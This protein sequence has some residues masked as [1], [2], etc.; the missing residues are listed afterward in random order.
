M[1]F[2]YQKTANGIPAG[3]PNTSGWGIL[4]P[5][6]LA[7]PACPDPAYCGVCPQ[8]PLAPGQGPYPHQETVYGGVTSGEVPLA[9]GWGVQQRPALP[10]SAMGTDP[11][12]ATITR[13]R[14]TLAISSPALAR[15]LSFLLFF[16]LCLF[17]FRL[18]C[19]HA[20]HAFLILPW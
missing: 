6:Q 1:A 2:T 10:A 3:F 8:P 15:V 20:Q 7:G 5:A 18:P 12:A 11:R 19:L 13:K 17:C 14:G 4:Q 16:L 9:S